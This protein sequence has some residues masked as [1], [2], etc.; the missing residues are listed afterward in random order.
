MAAGLTSAI[1]NPLV[2]QVRTTVQG[3]DVLL[4]H[5]RFARAWIQAY[6]NN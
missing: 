4:G 1:A 5:D 2:E 6:R 3:S